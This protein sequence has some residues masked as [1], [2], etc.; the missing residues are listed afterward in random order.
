MRCTQGVYNVPSG[1]CFIVHNSVHDSVHDSVQW[2]QCAVFNWSSH[3]VLRVHRVRIS[4]Y[5]VDCTV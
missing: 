3:G 1:Q 5:D 2:S 4:E